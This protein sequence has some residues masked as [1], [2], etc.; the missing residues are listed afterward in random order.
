MNIDLQKL[1]KVNR[2]DT[3]EK[4]LKEEI[5]KDKEAREQIKK[6]NMISK[7]Y[8]KV[9]FLIHIFNCMA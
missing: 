1:K 4:L 8:T 2:E 7:T 3:Q 5:R 6:E 9:Y